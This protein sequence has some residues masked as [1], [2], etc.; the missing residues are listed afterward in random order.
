MRWW[1][2]HYYLVRN[3]LPVDRPIWIPSPRLRNYRPEQ[4]IGYFV[5][6]DRAATLGQLC[7]KISTE[8][9]IREIKPPNILEG[10]IAFGSPLDLIKRT[11]RQTT[12]IDEFET[13]GAILSSPTREVDG[14]TTIV[15][16]STANQTKTAISPIAGQAV[17]IASPMTRSQAKSLSLKVLAQQHPSPSRGVR[18]LPIKTAYMGKQTIFEEDSSSDYSA[19][20]SISETSSSTSLTD[21]GNI[22]LDDNQEENVEVDVGE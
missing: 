1:S 4:G 17:A 7:R 5:E 16:P 19:D 11:E 13:P 9:P 12:P 22:L 20:T 10:W 15:A 6:R 14:Q 8:E 3:C 2:H 21:E 18:L